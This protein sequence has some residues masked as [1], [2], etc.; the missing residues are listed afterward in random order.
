MSLK[1][2]NRLTSKDFLKIQRQKGFFARSAILSIK[3]VK[4]NL[5]AS[6]FGFVVSAKV[7]KKAVERNKIKRQLRDVVRKNKD[8]IKKGFDVVVISSPAL[9]GM[10]YQEIKEDL[11]G[12][13][14]KLKLLNNA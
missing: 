10:K 2:Q 3:T 7:S 12:L 4:N 5:G 13:F 14:Q 1:K 11:I 6:R 8:N 9:K